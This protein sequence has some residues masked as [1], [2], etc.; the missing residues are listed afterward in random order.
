MPGQKL[1]TNFMS[2]DWSLSV[3]AE[4]MMETLADAFVVNGTLVVV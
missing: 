4:W 1:E 3:A 2:R